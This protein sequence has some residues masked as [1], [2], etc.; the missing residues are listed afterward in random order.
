MQLKHELK[1]KIFKGIQALAFSPTGKTLAAVAIDDDHCVAVYNVEN[2]AL[3]GTDKG[4]KAM[5]IELAFKN[6]TTFCSAGVKHFK[7][8]TIGA[9]LLQKRGQFGTYDQRIGSCKF[10]GDNCLT[11]SITGEVYVWTGTGIKAA[12]KLHEKPV[13]AIHCT[14]QYVFT[15]GRDFKV[16]VL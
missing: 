13:D 16:N 1:G 4:D 12:K 11:G 6:E 10:S 2:G 15:G 8:W 7:E 14:A 3:L 9:T 5:I